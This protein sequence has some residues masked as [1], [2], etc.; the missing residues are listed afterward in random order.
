MPSCHNVNLENDSYTLSPLGPVLSHYQAPSSCDSQGDQRFFGLSRPRSEGSFIGTRLNSQ[1]QKLARRGK[2][3]A[4]ALCNIKSEPNNILDA[5]PK[6]NISTLAPPPSRNEIKVSSSGSATRSYSSYLPTGSSARSRPAHIESPAKVGPKNTEERGAF[7]K[8]VAKNVEEH[9]LEKDEKTWNQEM[10]DWEQRKRGKP[11][12]R[13]R[14]KYTPLLKQMM[15]R[16]VKSIG[17]K[18]AEGSE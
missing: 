17:F 10:K 3:K 4:T 15:Q 2:A 16:I 12:R 1:H 9:A 6:S 18:R 8:I 13:R 5:S 11:L 14:Q 7:S